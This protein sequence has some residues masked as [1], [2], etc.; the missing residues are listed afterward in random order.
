MTAKEIATELATTIGELEVFKPIDLIEIIEPKLK[1]YA[2]AKSKQLSEAATECRE[3]QKDYF[4]NRWDKKRLEKAKSKEA[5]LDKL[6]KHHT[7]H[8]ETQKQLI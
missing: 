2:I 3:A 6:L 8:T 5:H 4:A 1:E 7:N